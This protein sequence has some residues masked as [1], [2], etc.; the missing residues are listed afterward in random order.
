M[1]AIGVLPPFFFKS[2]FEDMFI[3]LFFLFLEGRGD[4]EGGG[5]EQG[6]VFSLKT[7]SSCSQQCLFKLVIFRT[8]LR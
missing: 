7:Q 2:S 4:R 1:S 3:D 5:R 8:L 6:S